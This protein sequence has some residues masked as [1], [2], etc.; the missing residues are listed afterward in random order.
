MR[1]LYI[2]SARYDYLTATLIEGLSE[3]GHTVMC[4]R[5][6]NYGK[7]IADLRNPR[8]RGAS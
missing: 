6:S 1:I 7:A 3:L 5:N 4:S 8:R 2:N